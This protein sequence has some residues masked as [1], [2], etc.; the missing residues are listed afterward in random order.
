VTQALPALDRAPVATPAAL[1]RRGVLLVA[2][3]ALAWSSA[4]LIV[5]TVATDAWTTL[6]WRSVFACVS[7]LAYIA[8]RDR[9]GMAAAFTGIGWAGIALAGCFATSMICFIL[10]LEQTTVANVLIFQAAAP[11][12]AALLA[13]LVLRE[14]VS[15]RGI[16]AIVA[17]MF[18]IVIM[19]SD[20]VQTGRVGGDLLS[21]AMSLGFAGTIVLARHRRDL[22]MT[23][24]S[25][26]ATAMTALIA[27]PFAE[28]PFAVAPTDLLLLALF[29][30]GQMGLGL[31]CFM[32]GVRLLPAADA[33]L[34]SVLESVLGPLWVWLAFGE[35]PGTRAMIGGSI[36]LAAVV[37]HTL[38]ER[39]TADV[40][41]QV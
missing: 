9:R 36:V 22:A 39:R 3:A 25:C 8:I 6:F 30:I 20:S 12:I 33:G 34:I 28:H 29:G 27:L 2:G 40:A 37:L 11:F 41:G 17:T 4:G 10:A 16:A 5:R 35:N 13:W 32:A 14:R 19:V 21:A 38:V 18:G 31:V 15:A 26:L 23:P 1:Y 24:A 7:L